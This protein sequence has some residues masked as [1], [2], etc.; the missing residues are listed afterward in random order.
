[1][2]SANL[3]NKELLHQLAS[4]FH[5]GNDQKDLEPIFDCYLKAPFNEVAPHIFRF[6]ISLLYLDYTGAS[7]DMIAPSPSLKVQFT[8]DEATYPIR[9]YALQSR[10]ENNRMHLEYDARN[11]RWSKTYICSRC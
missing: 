10:G 1:M 11:I 5:H 9:T 3:K 8:T 4:Q 2:P 6:E 7:I